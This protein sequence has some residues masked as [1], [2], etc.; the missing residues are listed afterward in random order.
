MELIHTNLVT[1]VTYKITL[2]MYLL[3]VHIK[4]ACCRERSPADP[5][6]VL[7][8]GAFSVF[9]EVVTPIERFTT[10]V[11]HAYLGSC[12]YFLVVGKVHFIHA[13]YLADVAAVLC[14]WVCLCLMGLQVLHELAFQRK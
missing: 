5:A 11:A 8:M 2:A 3:V 10:N 13:R 1:D 6:H 9:D 4:F 14:W 12:M 7:T